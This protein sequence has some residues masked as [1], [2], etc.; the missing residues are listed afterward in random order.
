MGSS[1]SK[2]KRSEENKSRDILDTIE[3]DKSEDR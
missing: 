2:E 3:D 1:D